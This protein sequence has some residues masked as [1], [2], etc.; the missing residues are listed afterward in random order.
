MGN[1]QSGNRKRLWSLYPVRD[2]Q[3]QWS[4][5]SNKVLIRCSALTHN[6]PRG[7]GFLPHAKGKKKDEC[8][9]KTKK[10][11][12]LCLRYLQSTQASVQMRS[13][14]VHFAHRVRSKYGRFCINTNLLCSS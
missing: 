1:V 7:I 11:F 2:N 3:T 6:L 4:Q 14:S 5:H 9:P 8:V 12:R 10:I 13:I